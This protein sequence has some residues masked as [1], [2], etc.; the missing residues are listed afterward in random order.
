M[1]LWSSLWRHFLCVVS[2]PF[3][4]HLAFTKISKTTVVLPCMLKGSS[5]WILFLCLYARCGQYDVSR[6]WIFHLIS[7]RSRIFTSPPNPTIKAL[8]QVRPIRPTSA[9]H[10]L[11]SGSHHCTGACLVRA[12][13]WIQLQRVWFRPCVVGA[14]P[15]Y[16]R[17][18]QHELLEPFTICS[19][20]LKE[21]RLMLRF[22]NCLC[23][24]SILHALGTGYNSSLCVESMFQLWETIRR[25][26]FKPGAGGTGTSVTDESLLRTEGIVLFSRFSSK[27]LR[28]IRSRSYNS[29]AALDNRPHLRCLRLPIL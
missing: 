15:Y 18:S 13:A 11:D 26:L 29:L 3:H 6:Q 2:P 16:K 27:Q 28:S 9:C 20:S 5:I 17:I 23:N 7:R 22:F 12:Y 14:N 24:A 4:F 19:G 21:F 25:R 1:P 10:S 8:L